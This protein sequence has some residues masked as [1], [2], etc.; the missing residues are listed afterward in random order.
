ML[1]DSLHQN[2]FQM[3]ETST[4]WE[5]WVLEWESAM[6]TKHKEMS[7]INNFMN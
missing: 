3:V 5:K 4:F 1:S 7:L 6:G 2:D